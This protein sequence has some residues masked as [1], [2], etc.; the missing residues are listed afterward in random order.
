MTKNEL[1]IITNQ[2]INEFILRISNSSYLIPH[3]MNLETFIEG[4]LNDFRDGLSIFL[5]KK[6]STT[7]QFL[8][9]YTSKISGLISNEDFFA[10][11][12]SI[13]KVNDVKRSVDNLYYSSRDKLLFAI[14]ELNLNFSEKEF[15]NQFCPIMCSKIL[16]SISSGVSIKNIMN[17]Y[18]CLLKQLDNTNATNI[19]FSYYL[20]KSHSSDSKT[21]KRR[22]SK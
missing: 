20:S 11:L 12:S 5:K 6:D 17:E 14:D 7:S 10:V 19:L 13:K 21:K 15:L 3:G 1:Q 4:E 2:A 18:N 22:F 16:L 9:L 8:S